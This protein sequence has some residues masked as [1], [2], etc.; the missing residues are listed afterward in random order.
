MLTNFNPLKCNPKLQITP[1]YIKWFSNLYNDQIEKKEELS[2][3][4]KKN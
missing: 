2:T 3:S 1:K 4:W